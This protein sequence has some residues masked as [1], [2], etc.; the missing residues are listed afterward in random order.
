MPSPFLQQLQFTP[1][2]SSE[3]NKIVVMVCYGILNSFCLLCRSAPGA[4]N[5]RLYK[6]G[7]L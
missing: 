1:V 7:A 4:E 5:K 2:G 3:L 6:R